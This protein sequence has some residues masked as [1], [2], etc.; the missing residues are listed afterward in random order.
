MLFTTE[1]F[2]FDDQCSSDSWQDLPALTPTSILTDHQ[3]V[4]T[5]SSDDRNDPSAW[6]TCD[7]YETLPTGPKPRAN[8]GRYDRRGHWLLLPPTTERKFPDSCERLT[9]SLDLRVPTDQL[10]KEKQKKPAR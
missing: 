6:E 9:V 8:Y 2:K 1:K 4:K 5:S 10:I 7:D 3:Y